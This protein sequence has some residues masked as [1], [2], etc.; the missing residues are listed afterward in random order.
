M[1]VHVIN[2]APTW[3]FEELRI[4]DISKTQLGAVKM[5]YLHQNILKRINLP[6]TWVQALGSLAVDNAPAIVP[7]MSPISL[8]LIKS[9]AELEANII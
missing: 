7:G 5:H 8:N 6:D 3:R 9:I 4:G 2:V 1:F